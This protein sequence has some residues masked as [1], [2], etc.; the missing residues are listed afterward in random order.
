MRFVPWNE[1]GLQEV[2]LLPIGYACPLKPLRC[3]T[4]GAG[5]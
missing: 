1:Q 5:D 3:V 2:R 4:S